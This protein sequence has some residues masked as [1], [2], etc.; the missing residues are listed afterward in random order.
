[1]AHSDWAYFLTL[2]FWIAE[3]LFGDLSI[4][5]SPYKD[6]SLS[7]N[8]RWF[9]WGVE[10]VG[11]FISPLLGRSFWEGLWDRIDSWFYG[12]DESED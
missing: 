5:E 9:L 2:F 12:D 1:M 10:A 6:I 8:I 3:I 4:I 7:G 11:M